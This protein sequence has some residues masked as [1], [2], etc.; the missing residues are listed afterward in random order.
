[1][2]KDVSSNLCEV[3]SNSKLIVRIS[4]IYRRLT[5]LTF[6]RW[7]YFTRCNVSRKLLFILHLGVN[8]RVHVKSESNRNV[9]TNI[10]GN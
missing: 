2:S 5:S 1:M 6:I 9:N 3:L 8:G 7:I 4:A 10:D